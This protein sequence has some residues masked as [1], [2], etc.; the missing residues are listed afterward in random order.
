MKKVITALAAVTLALGLGACSTDAEVARHNM[1]K[2]AEQFN[3]DRRIVF[4]NGITDEYMLEV[5]GKCSYTPEGYQ[6]VVICKTGDDEYVKHSMIRSD[7]TTVV[8]EQTEAVPVD[9]YHH[10]VIFRPESILPD[11]DIET[12]GSEG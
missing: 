12:S 3:I 4:I 7:N 2:D 1:D 8:V 6:V 5:T 10:K 9:V 11:V